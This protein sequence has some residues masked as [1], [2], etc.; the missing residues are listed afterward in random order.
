MKE[1]GKGLLFGVFIIAG[2][3]WFVHELAELLDV[4]NFLDLQ[5]LVWY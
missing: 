2:A 4:A 1:A 5:S 3:L